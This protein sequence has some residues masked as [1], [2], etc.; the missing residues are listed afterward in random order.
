MTTQ[1]AETR[2]PYAL[3]ANI[4]QVKFALSSNPAAACA[5][6]TLSS[7]FVTDVLESATANFMAQAGECQAHAKAAQHAEDAAH[8]LITGLMLSFIPNWDKYKASEAAT[9]YNRPY[10]DRKAMFYGNSSETKRIYLSLQGVDTYTA[11]TA[12]SRVLISHA[13]MTLYLFSEADARIFTERTGQPLK[14][15]HTI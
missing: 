5:F 4:T 13:G 12:P 11:K 15:Y 3:S 6:R 2:P 7:H 14:P 1:T 8:A 9:D 10:F